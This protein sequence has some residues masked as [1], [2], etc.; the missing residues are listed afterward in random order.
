METPDADSRFSEQLQPVDDPREAELPESAPDEQTGGIGPKYETAE[1][2]LHLLQLLTAGDCTRQDIFERMRDYYK[3]T[4]DPRVQ[5]ASQR[6]GRMLLRDLAFLKTMGYEIRKLQTG[7][8]IRYNLVKGSGPGGMFLF[9][10]DELDTL[11]LLH[12]F[13]ADPTKYAPPDPTQPLPRQPLHNPLA[14]GVL[15]LMERLVEM[16]PPEQKKYFDRW[17]RKPYIYFNLDTVTNYLPH[18]ATIDTIVRY[19]SQRQQ[20]RFEYA[21]MQRRQGTTLHEHVDPY[22][23]IH[24]DGHLYLIGYSHKMNTFYEYRIDRIKAESLRPEHDMIDGE[25]RRH[26]I[27]FSYWIDANIARGGL[28]QRWLAHTIEREEAYLDEQGNQRRRVLVRAKAYSD[29]RILQQ[30]HK[31]GDKAELVDP[32]EL[33]ERMRQEVARM[34]HMYHK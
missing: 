8:T 23:I 26:P 17:A 6:A 20:I 16:L 7:G 21:S 28:S 14:E 19:I 3:V 34:Y 24:Q 9:H 11:V 2:I 4:D 13:F 12:T 33:R 15:S 1:R 30:L 18:R 31:Y 10:Q 25:R 27:E 5:A 32:P 22:Y 29:W